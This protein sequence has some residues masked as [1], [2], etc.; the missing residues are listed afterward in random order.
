MS[1]LN[2]SSVILGKQKRLEADCWIF[3]RFFVVIIKRPARDACLYIGEAT[4]LDLQFLFTI[5]LQ[6]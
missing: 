1:W 4:P 2:W 6:P 3:D 5:A